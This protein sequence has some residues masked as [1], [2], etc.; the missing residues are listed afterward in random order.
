VPKVEEEALLEEMPELPDWLAEAPAERVEELEWTPPA[1]EITPIDLNTASLVDL[2]RLPEIGFI[3]AQQIIN[4][5]EAHGP[6]IQI[7]DLLRVPGCSP[8]TLT[9]VKEYLFVEV[10]QEAPTV[11]LEE[12]SVL[13]ETMDAPIEIKDARTS[14]NM[15]E[16]DAAFAKYAAMIEKGQYLDLIIDDLREVASRH[17][18]DANAWQNL[19]DA[20][21]H[22]NQVREALD[23]YGQ[24]ERLLR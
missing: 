6:F 20:Y 13:P 1:A 21:L 11:R 12:T 17:P 5:R 16:M 9:V 22:A 23:A 2:E 14:M 3:L 7:E 10:P 24:A 15:G 18:E 4:F 19:G 8:T